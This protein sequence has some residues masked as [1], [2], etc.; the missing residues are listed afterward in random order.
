[1][2]TAFLNRKRIIKMK[3]RLQGIGKDEA[4]HEDVSATPP[5]AP[6]ATSQSVMPLNTAVHSVKHHA[7]KS[8]FSN[9]ITVFRIDG[10]QGPM[11][12]QGKVKL[13]L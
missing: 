5:T 1:M 8:A 13:S 9:L 6:T 12:P 7:L 2:G 3:F 10:K 4:G 11:R